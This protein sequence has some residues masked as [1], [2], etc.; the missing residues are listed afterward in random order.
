MNVN[1][2]LFL[3]FASDFCTMH[4]VPLLSSS[5]SLTTAVVVVLVSSDS[6]VQRQ[7]VFITTTALKA[8][9]TV[10]IYALCDS[11]LFQVIAGMYL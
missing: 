10:E 3:L 2:G 11:L 9:F 6:F 5:W 4:K 1:E 7:R 8:N